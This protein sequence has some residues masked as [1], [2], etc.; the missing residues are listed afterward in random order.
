M[1]LPFI[2]IGMKTDLSSP[3]ATAEFSKL[4][5]ILNATLSQHHLSGFEIASTITNEL[6]HRA[7][8]FV[9]LSC[10]KQEFQNID[11]P[12]KS[13]PQ[14]SGPSK[15]KVDFSFKDKPKPCHIHRKTQIH[16]PFEKVKVTQ[17]Y[18]TLCDPMHH[19]VHGI[20]RARILEVIVVPF[21]RGSSQH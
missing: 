11:F 7:Q 20:L 14:N 3:V 19:T 17:S 16:F 21:S 2:G 10:F 6:S 13:A 4:A 15:F 5:G 18:A 9:H 8:F 12:G 1:A